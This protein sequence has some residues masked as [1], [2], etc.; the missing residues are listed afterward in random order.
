MERHKRVAVPGMERVLDVKRTC[1]TKTTQDN[2]VY[3]FN[4]VTVQFQADKYL[5]V[6]C[7]ALAQV[8]PKSDD[9]LSQVEGCFK[10]LAFIESQDFDHSLIP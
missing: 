8:G 2:K 4:P 7:F 6:V 1:S 3:V 9:F 10:F 5:D